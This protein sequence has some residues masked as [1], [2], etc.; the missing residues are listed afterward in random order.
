MPPTPN[1][2]RVNSKAI[3]IAVA[4]DICSV[5]AFVLAG[6][7][8]HDEM[9]AVAGIAST[10]WPFLAGLLV[11]WGVRRA[12]HRPL[13]VLRT[14]LPVAAITVAVGMILRVISGQG[15]AVAFILVACVVLGV[16]LTGWRALGCTVA[17]R[18]RQPLRLEETT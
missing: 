15:T 1:E 4:A 11:G 3:T 14:G 13:S 16:L 6:R 10:A 8:S 9:T 18:R 2:Q 12:W 7:R 17:S 5:L